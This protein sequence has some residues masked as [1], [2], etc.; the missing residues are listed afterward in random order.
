MS[1]LALVITTQ[2]INLVKG[3]QHGL[4]NGYAELLFKTNLLH[5]TPNN[6][7]HFEGGI[8][9][10]RVLCN[11]VINGLQLERIYLADFNV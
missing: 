1:S 9:T 6:T 2:Y 10:C 11:P 5:C 7:K 8:L 4:Y 3:D